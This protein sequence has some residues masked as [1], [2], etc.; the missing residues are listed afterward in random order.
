MTLDGWW[1][2]ARCRWA[3]ATSSDAW[4]SC[5]LPLLQKLTVTVIA[6]MAAGSPE[7]ITTVNQTG[8]R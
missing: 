4:R 8:L 7:G 1:W 3:Q 5:L 6:S 2:V